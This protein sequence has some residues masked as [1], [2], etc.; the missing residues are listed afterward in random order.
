MSTIQSDPSPGT[1]VLMKLWHTAC[2]LTT[3]QS[4]KKATRPNGR[5][6]LHFNKG[7]LPASSL[8][9]TNAQECFCKHELTW[10][11]AEQNSCNFSFSNS[12]EVKC[13]KSSKKYLLGVPWI[14]RWC[15]TRCLTEQRL[16]N[17]SGKGISVKR[18]WVIQID[19]I[20]FR[21]ILLHVKLKKGD[22][23]VTY[24]SNMFIIII[25][26]WDDWFTLF[27]KAS[28]HRRFLLRFNQWFLLW[29][30]ITG[31]N[32]WQFKSPRNH[33]KLTWEILNW[34]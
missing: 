30:Q 16:G 32:Y 26:A 31:V 10:P 8:I 23:Q 25:V 29:F 14:S 33:Q 21:I 12:E 3:K 6:I 7:H 9:F 1:K 2:T 22:E 5:Y 34:H 18:N 20:V 4:F 17:E 13:D 28:S 19:G 24:L 15:C 11:S 27:V